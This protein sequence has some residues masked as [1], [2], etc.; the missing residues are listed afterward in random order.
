M[1]DETAAESAQSS[2]PSRQSLIVL[3]DIESSPR[4][5]KI[6]FWNKWALK[7]ETAEEDRLILMK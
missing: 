7:P 5:Q 4:K 2:G 1:S 6:Y 3:E